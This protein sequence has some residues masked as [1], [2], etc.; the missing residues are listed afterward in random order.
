MTPEPLVHSSSSSWLVCLWNLVLHLL[1]TNFFWKHW[2]LTVSSRLT[3]CCLRPAG[4]LT[5]GDIVLYKGRQTPQPHSQGQTHQFSAW[6]GGRV[7]AEG[8]R[9]PPMRKTAYLPC[10]RVGRGFSALG[11]QEKCLC[12]VPSSLTVTDT[13]SA[14]L[15]KCELGLCQCCPETAVAAQNAAPELLDQRAAHLSPPARA[16]YLLQNVL[17]G[18]VSS[19]TADP[20]ISRGG[21][22]FQILLDL[23]DDTGAYPP[24]H[25]HCYLCFSFLHVHSLPS[26]PY[27]E[28]PHL[29]QSAVPTGHNQ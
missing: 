12:R 10:L 29:C 15:P 16:T 23:P 11:L 20:H 7:A 21:A 26:P 13:F 8:K 17:Q 5:P 22:L 6:P 3:E 28:H 1:F 14:L 4:L 18:S 9:C 27:L 2:N 25:H 24:S 19:H